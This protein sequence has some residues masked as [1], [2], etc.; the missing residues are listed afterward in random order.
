MLPI[1]T[2]Q[3]L[4]KDLLTVR[5]RITLYIVPKFFIEIFKPAC[6]SATGPIVMCTG[7]FWPVL[8][9]LQVVSEI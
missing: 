4:A 2:T 3:N 8:S 6:L 9:L 7:G 1:M 5:E